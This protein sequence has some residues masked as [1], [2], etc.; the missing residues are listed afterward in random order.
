M[1]N[2]SKNNP[3]NGVI[4]AL[5]ISKQKGIKKNNVLEV[6]FVPDHGIEGDAHAGSGDRQV[7]L[8]AIESI[9]KIIAKGL[10]VGPG[11]FAENVTTKGVELHTLPLGTKFLLDGGVELL[12]TQIGKVCHERCAIYYEAGDC[13]M[14]R[15]GIFCR[16]IKGGAVQV[17]AEMGIILPS[18]R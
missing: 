15:E 3:I 10:D 7:S 18:N 5:S 8:L 11:D 16:V 4:A 12:V 9:D 1:N 2:Q 14:P 13:V 17:G 6:V